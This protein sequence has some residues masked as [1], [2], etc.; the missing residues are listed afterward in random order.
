M[1]NHTAF[2]EVMFHI[3]G[4]VKATEFGVKIY[5]DREHESDSHKGN[6]WCALASD[7]MNGP[8][9]CAEVTATA[10]FEHYAQPQIL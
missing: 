3:F 2:S 5:I 10:N 6:M 4:S 7:F 9:I 8:F 1:T